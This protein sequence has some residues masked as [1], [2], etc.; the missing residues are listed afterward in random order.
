MKVISR[1]GSGVATAAFSASLAL[2]HHSGA[3][4]DN[5]K[6]VEIAGTVHEFQWTNPHVFIEL[7]VAGP[8]GPQKFII[9]SPTP[10]VLKAHGWKFNTLK[11][12]DKVVAKVHPLREGRV[13]GYLVAM[14]KDGVPIGD[15][16]TTSNTIQGNK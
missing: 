6:E 9:E 10:G 11:P 3:M 2:A 5:T 1:I 14:S 4:F 7:M 15:G 8:K 16:G 12:G 13:G